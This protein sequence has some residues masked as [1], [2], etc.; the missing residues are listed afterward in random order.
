MEK[1]TIRFYTFPDIYNIQLVHGAAVAHRFP[2]HIHGSVSFGIVEHG[3]RVLEIQGNTVIVSAGECFII[4]P[5]EPHTCRSS[6]DD[7]HEYW[8]LS[9]PPDVIHSLWNEMTGTQL[10]QVSFSPPAIRD[11]Q[12]FQMLEDFVDGVCHKDNLLRQESL[13]IEIITY[14]LSRYIQ[15]E[16]AF[17]EIETHHYAVDV[18]REYLEQHFE[19][20]IRLEDLAEVS[21]VSPFYLN[22]LFQRAV[23]LPPYE[24]L[25]HI[26]IK[27]AR[28]LLENGESIAGTAYSTGFS[29]QSHLTR[30]FKRHVGLTPGEYLRIHVT[31]HKRSRP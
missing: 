12:L 17:Q 22:R 29:D 27:R 28:E 31:S 8:I 14:C 1:S 11:Q 2:R 5:N 25:V 9:V 16:C 24:Y 15:S 21:H 13:C 20:N 18:V 26:R 23:G 30:F 4:N 6:L 19:Q 7:N 10:G 3:K